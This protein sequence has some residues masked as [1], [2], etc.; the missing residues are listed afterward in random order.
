MKRYD[1]KW[2]FI[3]KWECV[4]CYYY[5]YC[6]ECAVHERD[7]SCVWFNINRDK[8][9][10]WSIALCGMQHRHIRLRT[11]H[12]QFCIVNSAVGCCWGRGDASITHWCLELC[13]RMQCHYLQMSFSQ[14]AM[15]HAVE[16]C[17][18]IHWQAELG[19]VPT[20]AATWN[21][22]I[23]TCDSSASS[24]IACSTTCANSS[25]SWKNIW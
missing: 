14:T 4:W 7:A 15:Q 13:A 16:Y 10:W 18:H 19:L 22:S 6:S 20:T 1:T 2:R 24:I 8:F 3:S 17:V 11:P 21:R 25:S 5:Y 23:F 9:V 12:A